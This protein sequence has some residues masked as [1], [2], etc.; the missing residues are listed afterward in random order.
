MKNL[1]ALT[2]AV[3]VSALTLG[4]AGAAEFDDVSP[5]DWYFEAVDF[6]VAEELFTGVGEG[7]FEPA[8]H[9]NRAMFVTVLWRLDGSEAA[10]ES[11]TEPF[12]DVPEDGWYAEA[13][14][15]ASGAGIVSGSGEGRFSPNESITRE[16]AA[17]LIY[18]YMNYK[19]YDTTATDTLERFEDVLSISYYAEDAMRWSVG[20]GLFDGRS[21]TLLTPY[22][23]M[24]R[25]ETATLFMRLVPAID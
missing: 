5:E 1:L 20:A 13:V 2:V 16:S 8:T 6:V 17:T 25:A 7:R 18:R 19:E 15:W 3:M 22:D 9:M 24:T 4:V 14:Y 11:A 21:A 12:S 23:Y 10:A